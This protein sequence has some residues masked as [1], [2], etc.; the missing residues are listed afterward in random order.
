MNLINAIEKSYLYKNLFRDVSKF[1]RENLSDVELDK[2]Y[3]LHKAGLSKYS[4]VKSTF[5]G[6]SVLALGIVAGGLLGLALA[7]KR[8]AD[9]RSEVK[10][11]AMNF[12]NKPEIRGQTSAHA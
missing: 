1:V 2:S 11:K 9:L 10:D 4:P 3:W 5:G 7:P 8:G 12:L 6:I